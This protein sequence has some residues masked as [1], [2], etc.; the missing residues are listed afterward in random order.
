M[1]FVGNNH[2]GGQDFNQRLLEYVLVHIDK[3]LQLRGHNEVR[4]NA[5]DM[6]HV[7]D[8]VEIAKLN[9]SVNTSSVIKLQL[10]TIANNNVMKINITRELFEKISQDLFQ[11]VL[12]P[13]KIV[14]ND[15]ELTAEDIEE[16]VLVG[17]STRIPRVREL[18]A[19]YFGKTPNTKIDPE[20]AVTSGVS[21]QAGILGGMW[22]L[23]VSAVELPTQARK[24][25]IK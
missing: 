14:L 20:V 18:I 24:I 25:H 15:V 10:T 5:E 4:L 12:E 6:Q 2:L 16:I 1:I 9:L 3:E 7:R 13:I 19:E 8:S 23:T 22:P 17:G 11:K 21:I